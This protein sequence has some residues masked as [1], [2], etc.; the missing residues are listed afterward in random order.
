[1]CFQ[2]DSIHKL[3]DSFLILN[4]INTLSKTYPSG[5]V[6]VNFALIG[7]EFYGVILIV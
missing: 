6:Y 2:S 1:M 7:I 4:K 5:K 3:F